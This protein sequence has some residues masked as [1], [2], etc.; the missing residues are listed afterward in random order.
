MTTHADDVFP[1]VVIGGGLAGL[2]AAIH[3]AERDV[4]PLV[5]EADSEWPGGCLSAG[6]PD[7]FEHKGRAWSFLS[8]HGAHALW[9]GYDNMRAMLDRFLDINLLNSWG[10]EWINRWGS[11]VTYFEAGT[12]VRRSWLPAPFHYLQMLFTPRFWRTI[13]LLDLF[14]SPSLA[15]SIILST[16]FDPIM[17]QR[18]IPN[19]TIDDYFMLWSPNLRAIFRGL[20][21]SLLAAP[22]EHITL[23]GFI[24]AMRFFTMLRQDTWSLEY[25]PTNAHDCLIQPMIDK[26]NANGQV[27]L[28]TRAVSLKRN[29]DYWDVRVEDARLGGMRTLTA[30]NVIIATE[31][32]AA[33][34]LLLADD[35]DTAEA[36][37]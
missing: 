30:A 33:E 18:E 29:G 23:A 24:A 26:I 36:A 1:V 4:P 34:R 12:A 9:G 13:T 14:A 21:H 5:L 31:P 20:G 19:R 32:N 11:K 28:G 7:T 22:S 2:S 27:M 3:L 6:A 8:E 17:E 15:A 10:E 37:R 16:G 25:L 35:S